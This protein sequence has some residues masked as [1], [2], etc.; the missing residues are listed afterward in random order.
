MIEKKTVTQV[1]I[2]SN[3]I[4]Y[5]VDSD[6]FRS[7]AMNFSLTQNVVKDPETW[8]RF[9]A[10]ITAD[11]AVNALRE[12]TSN[13]KAKGL[14][15]TTFEW[16]AKLAQGLLKLQNRAADRDRLLSQLPAQLR[17]KLEDE[18]ERRSVARDPSP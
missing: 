3:T 4:F 11:Q 1:K 8:V 2:F 7:G 16:P 9:E 15:T 12:I 5:R 6:T 14:P 17:S 13:I 10:G 18:L